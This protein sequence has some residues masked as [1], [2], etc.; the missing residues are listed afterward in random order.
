MRG[1]EVSKDWWEFVNTYE[2]S[3]SS[4]L[5]LDIIFCQKYLRILGIEVEDNDEQWKEDTSSKDDDKECEEDTSSEDDDNSGKKI[6]LVKMGEEKVVREEMTNLRFEKVLEFLELSFPDVG[7]VEEEEEMLTNAEE[8]YKVGGGDDNEGDGGGNDDEDG[9]EDDSYG[10]K[11]DEEY[12]GGDDGEGHWEDG[13]YDQDEEEDE[14]EEDEDKDD[15]DEKCEGPL[16]GKKDYAN[17]NV[18]DLIDEHVHIM[19]ILEEYEFI[20]EFL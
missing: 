10:D 11:G 3:F 5:Y 1:Y 6:H 17:D 7:G 16:D 20:G 14:D 19:D 15:K 12:S 18:D 13:E 9:G 4:T 8:H 2:G